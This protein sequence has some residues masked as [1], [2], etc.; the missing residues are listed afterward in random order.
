MHNPNMTKV[1]ENLLVALVNQR[2]VADLTLPNS[3]G[4]VV[5]PPIMEYLDTI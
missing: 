1:Q 4:S 5:C 2:R 3:S